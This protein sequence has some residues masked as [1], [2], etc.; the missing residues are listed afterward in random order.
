LDEILNTE[1]TKE[2]KGLLNDKENKGLLNDKENKGL[3]NDKENKG[4]LNDKENK[5]YI[6]INII[7]SESEHN[8]LLNN[9]N[10]LLKSIKKN[11]VKENPFLKNRFNSNK[12]LLVNKN[13]KLIDSAKYNSAKTQ[14]LNKS[15]DYSSDDKSDSEALNNFNA[16]NSFNDFTNKPENKELS[17]NLPN[18]CSKDVKKEKENMTELFAKLEKE[19]QINKKEKVII[20]QENHKIPNNNLSEI[21]PLKNF[22]ENNLNNGKAE[23]LKESLNKSDGNSQDVYA[24]KSKDNLTQLS[25]L[26]IAE[27]KPQDEIENDAQS[28]NEIQ[29]DKKQKNYDSFLNNE[30]NIL[31]YFDKDIEIKQESE[32]EEIENK[33]DPILNKNY[34][35]EKEQK[36]INNYN[37][38]KIETYSSID[39]K[40]N[41]VII[42]LQNNEAGSL[43]LNY[44]VNFFL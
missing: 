35:D 26:N 30:N 31:K 17:A 28:N 21:N 8:T 42:P 7:N 39:E 9:F 13:K 43:K 2:N 44:N 20:N 37:E 10:T 41:P 25:Q 15:L 33:A 19:K 5:D 3:L 38:I 14:N 23:D 24:E 29:N 36:S 34:K 12:N 11:P 6:D 40:I 22:S 16:Y 32:G 18:S 1:S 4:L 27:E